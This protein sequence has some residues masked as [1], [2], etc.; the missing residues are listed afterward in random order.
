MFTGR[1]FIGFA[2]TLAVVVAG[3]VGAWKW[4]H[5]RP[6][7]QPS[8]AVPGLYWLTFLRKDQEAPPPD[9][10]GK[11]PGKWGACYLTTVPGEDGLFFIIPH[12]CNTIVQSVSVDANGFK[13]QPKPGDAHPILLTGQKRKDGVYTVVMDDGE[14]VTRL[15]MRQVT[16]AELPPESKTGP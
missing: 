16:E 15:A 11:S 9:R 5:P 10:F 4:F 3:A 13:S 7:Q 1:K 2:V 6:A 12:P 8:A 14:R